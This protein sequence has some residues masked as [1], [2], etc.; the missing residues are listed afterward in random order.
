MLGTQKGNY[1]TDMV[2]LNR[3]YFYMMYLLCTLCHSGISDSFFDAGNTIKM[4]GAS[5]KPEL[6]CAILLPT[7]KK[8]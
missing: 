5:L 8:K 6:Q 4:V 1:A 7:D 3:F 2:I